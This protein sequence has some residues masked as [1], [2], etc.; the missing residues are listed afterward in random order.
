MGGEW[1]GTFQLRLCGPLS[2]ARGRVVGFPNRMS[3]LARVLIAIC[4]SGYGDNQELRRNRKQVVV[5]STPRM[6]YFLELPISSH[7]QSN[8]WLCGR[9]IYQPT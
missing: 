9:A 2:G 6:Y 3:E 1:K 8:V 4:E 7:M 5:I